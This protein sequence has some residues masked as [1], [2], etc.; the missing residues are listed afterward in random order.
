VVADLVGKVL[1]LNLVSLLEDDG[2]LDMFSSS[3]TFPGQS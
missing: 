2:A 1:D 3:R